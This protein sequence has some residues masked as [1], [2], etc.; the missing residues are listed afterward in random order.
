M[1]TGGQ[2]DAMTVYSPFALHAKW[3]QA[4]HD[5]GQTFERCLNSPWKRPK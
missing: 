4:G 1:A 5:P 2:P 3:E